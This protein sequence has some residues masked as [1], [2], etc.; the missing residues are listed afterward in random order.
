MRQKHTI[1][2]EITGMDSLGQGVSKITD[3]VTFIPKTV[4]GD[5]GEAEI[6]SE[7]KGV[8]FARMTKLGQSSDKRVTP[9][10]V[11]FANCPSCHYLHVDY[12][13]ELLYKKESFERLFRKLPL[14]ELE[15]VGAN[16][17]TAYR[18]RVQ[19][20]YSLKSKLLGMRDPQTFQITSI[21]KCLIG[22]P[23]VQKELERLYE[24]NQWLKE[25]P[26]A[27][28]EGHVEIY[29]INNDLKV[30]WNRPY[31]EGGFTQV[32]EEMNQKLKSILHHSWNPEQPT[33][34]LDLFGG[35]GNLSDGLNYSKRLCVDMYQKIPGTDFLSQDLYD[36][37]AL[38]NIKSELKKRSMKVE[39]L[40]LDPP[41]SGLKNLKVWIE[42]LKPKTIAYVSCDPHTLARD[43]QSLEGYHL[44]KAFLIDFFPSTFHFES[45]IILERNQ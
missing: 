3:K 27:P 38:K 25:A 1:T 14:P 29:W 22:V 31:A 12:A 21:P 33:E 5:K 24:N 2:F 15:V 40:L 39:H 9:A 26:P 32:F 34:L 10:C 20:H 43:V 8:A 19:L 42:D 41:R 6:L 28:L 35:N 16:R 23:E 18:N 37:R 44:K 36:E 4:V 13:Q 11:H 30:S 45:F 17:R 7:K